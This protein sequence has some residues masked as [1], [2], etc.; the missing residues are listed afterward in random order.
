MPCMKLLLVVIGLLV[1]FEFVPSG[2][3]APM[4]KEAAKASN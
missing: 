2:L 4:A 3:A 1:T